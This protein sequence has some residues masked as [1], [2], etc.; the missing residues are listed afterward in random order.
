MEPEVVYGDWYVVEH[1]HGECI[2][3]ECVGVLP[4]PEAWRPLMGGGEEVSEDWLFAMFLEEVDLPNEAER[5]RVAS[6]MAEEAWGEIALALKD[7]VLCRPERVRSVALQKGWGARFQMP[8][9]LDAT[10]WSVYDS[11]EEAFAALKDED[12]SAFPCDDCGKRHDEFDDCAFD[13][14][15]E[16][17][18]PLSNAQLAAALDEE[19]ILSSAVRVPPEHSVSRDD[20][21]RDALRENEHGEVFRA[22]RR[23]VLRRRADAL[24]REEVVALLE[25][26]CVQCYDHERADVLRDVLTDAILDGDIDEGTVHGP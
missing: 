13:E 25:G 15:R 1:D 12:P 23:A 10:E 20:W 8:G 22:V 21:L 7:Y 17:A 11:E 5:M 16:L 9:Y 26:I 6:E 19:L 14:A 3:A 4:L 2:P 24:S 18:R